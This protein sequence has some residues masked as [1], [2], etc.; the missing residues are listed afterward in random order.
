M[1]SQSAGMTF[2][3]VDAS[4]IV[5]ANVGASSG[6]TSSPASGETERASASAS[7]AGGRSPRSPRGTPR[8]SGPSRGA[9]AIRRQ[10]LDERRRLHERVVGDP[11]HRRVPA[12]AAHAQQERRAHLLGGRAEV[13]GAAGDLDA[14]AAA[15]VDRVVGAARVRMLADEPVEPEAVA[16]LLVG[17]GDE[18]EV[19]AAAH[20]SRARLAIATALAATWP[21]MSSAPRP[22]TNP[23]RS[24]P[25]NGSRSTRPRRPARRRCAR[26]ARATA[27]RRPAEPRDE[28][29]ALRH[30]RVQLAL[31][32]RVL[33]VGPQQ[34]GRRASRCRAG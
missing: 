25:P 24:S 1:S 32:A 33:E 19:A 20:P 26:A 13:E 23:S 16:D 28:V 11:R 14:V 15:L 17:R 27:R 5:G 18:D 31:D 22:Q 2:R 29:R 21:F 10:P 7:S 30:L 8:V 34:L 6:S 12:A 3:S 4:T 9:G